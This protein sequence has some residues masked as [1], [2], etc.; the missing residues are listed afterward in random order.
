MECTEQVLLTKW[1]I[2]NGLSSNGGFNKKQL[3]ILGVGWP[4]QKGWKNELIGTMISQKQYQDFLNAK[5]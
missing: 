2:E 1:M 3:E 4:P 5:K